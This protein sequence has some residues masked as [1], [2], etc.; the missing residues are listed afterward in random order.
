GAVKLWT[1][2]QSATL[3]PGEQARMVRSESSFTIA[4]PLD[5]ASEI[6][7]KSGYFNFE[8]ASI[9]EIMRQVSRWY[10]VEIIYRGTVSDTFTVMMWPR[11]QPVSQLLEL[12]ELTG[13]VKF[14]IEGRRVIVMR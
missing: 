2:T 1:G 6:A 10:D 9:E 3:R 5:V 14:E 12:L 4:G 8:D 7:W 13:H 11:N